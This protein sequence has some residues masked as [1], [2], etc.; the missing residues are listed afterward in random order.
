MRSSSYYA[1][2]SATANKN[3]WQ[4]LPDHLYE[5][6]RIASFNARIFNGESLAYLAGLLHDLGKYSR[7]FQARL[8]GSQQRADHATA[9]A[10]VAAQKYGKLG[11]LIAFAIAGHHAG[12]SNGVDEGKGRSTLRNRLA[13]KM[14]GDRLPA[15]ASVWEKEISLPEKVTEPAFNWDSAAFG[16]QLAFLTR[17]IFSCLIDADRTDTQSYTLSLQGKRLVPTHY[18]SLLDLREKLDGHLTALAKSADKTELNALRGRILSFSRQQA[19]L[20]KGLFSMTVPTG[21]GKTLASM[22]FALD[23]ALTHNQRRVIYVIPFTSII[24]QNAKVFKEAFGNLSHAVVEHHSAFDQDSA[25]SQGSSLKTTTSARFDDKLRIAM[26]SWSAP[27]IVTT[28]VQFFESLFADRPS[29]CRKLHNIAGS[30]IVL[31]EAQTLPLKLLR[32]IMAVIKELARNYQC[33]V[34]LCTATQ[35]A[36]LAKNGFY[37]GFEDVAEIAPEP[38]LLFKALKRTLVQP[39]GENTDEQLLGYLRA[40]HQV[41]MIVNNRRHARTLYDAIKVEAGA[42]HL[43]TLMI[44]K[45]RTRVLDQVRLCLKSG[46]PC[47][48]ISTSLIE[49]GVDVDFPRVYRAEAGLD[50]VAQ[51]AGR[52]NREGKRPLNDSV[53]GVFQSPE[54]P[55]P[56]ELDQLAGNMR[57]VLRNHS[58]DVLA[59]DAIKM[60]FNHVYS[61]RTSGAV[62]GLDIKK[63]LEMHSAHQGAMTF[64]FQNIAKEFTMIESHLLPVIVPSDPNASSLLDRLRFADHVGGIARELQP[65]L[66]QVPKNGFESLR[67]FGAISVIEP[68][69]FGDQFW[70]LENMNLYDS[71]AGLSWDDPVFARA[72]ST[73]L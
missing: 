50:S 32:P 61:G 15:I 39:L 73:V 68:Q 67:K 45:D 5:V 62:D 31:D 63:L 64:P 9:G 2:S 53:V 51:A 11:Q 72:E 28:A 44:A 17:M 14:G 55:A 10:Q 6:A 52:C 38:E 47:K 18:P 42:F 54:W 19:Q 60:Y 37:N 33:T 40:H 29:Q 30:V 41:L 12:L 49:A 48:L 57:A 58:G 66:V 4:S 36:L 3:E 21:G 69:K 65:Y 59:P 46:Q 25:K 16:L 13:L 34:V 70:M 22:A 24:E 56:P 1:H 20:P 26:E 71:H 35:P 8:E 27:V 7:E 43:S 23:H